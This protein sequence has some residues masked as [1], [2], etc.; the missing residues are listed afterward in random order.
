MP[1]SVLPAT[2]A[3]EIALIAKE[4]ISLIPPLI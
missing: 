1:A 4:L 3:K 2:Q